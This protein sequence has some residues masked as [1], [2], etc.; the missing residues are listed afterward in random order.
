M[1][2]LIVSLIIAFIFLYFTLNGIDFNE[3]LNRL[4]IINYKFIIY[5]FIFQ[6]LVGVSRAYRLKILFKYKDET[7][8]I[9]FFHI[10]NVGF[11]FTV[12][13]PLRLGE[14]TIP[15]LLKKELNYSF[16]FSLA[17]LIIM[18]LIDLVFMLIVLFIL[19]YFYFLPDWIIHSLQITSL[20]LIAL[21]FIFSL[22]FYFRNEIYLNFKNKLNLLPE[23]LK[24][25]ILTFIKE[26]ISGLKNINGPL[27]FVEISISTLLI[28][29]FTSFAIYFLFIT[30]NLKLTYFNAI[31][32]MNINT[33]S[34]IIPSGPA[35]IGN[36]QY[37]C[38][39]ALSLFNIEKNIGFLFGNLYYISGISTIL[40]YGF[41]SFFSIKTDI[42][43]LKKD[44]FTLQNK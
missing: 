39:V 1:K 16:S 25:L 41:L 38:I 7:K 19:L 28:W 20:I 36:F 42:S 3:V 4:I 31:L 12:L 43:D 44:I 9:N 40:F 18:R 33:L 17:S 2:K 35:M 14:F 5:I 11:M 29:T 22:S 8:F 21:L 32:V 34:A 24:I 6:F 13:L 10:N 26:F 23:K 30:M 15:Y 27:H 37:S